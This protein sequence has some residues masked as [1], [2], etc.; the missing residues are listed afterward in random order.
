MRLIIS[1]KERAAETKAEILSH[2]DYEVLTQDDIKYF[3]FGPASFGVETSTFWKGDTIVIPARGHIISSGIRRLRTAKMHE[4]PMFEIMWTIRKANKSRVKV[5]DELLKESSEVIVATDYDREGETIGYN[6]ISHL[7]YKEIPKLKPSAVQRAYYSAL[8]ERDVMSAFENLVPMD[9]ALL[10]QGLARDYS[11]LVIG[12]NL[13]K[14]LT[15]LFKSENPRVTQAFS[16]GRVQSPVLKHLLERTKMTYRKEME[17]FEDK[18]DAY[19]HHI[20]VDGYDYR[21][22]DIWYKEPISE[23]RV[24]D[25]RVE[26]KEEDQAEELFNT[27]DIMTAIEIDPKVL[28]S[29][30]ES[31]YLDGYMT[32]PRTKSRYVDPETLQSL[33]RKIRGY[34]DIPEEFSHEYAPVGTEGK[35]PAIVLT[36]KG[37]EALFQGKVKGHRKLVADVVLNQMVKSFACPLKKTNTIIDIEYDDEERTLTWESKIENMEHAITM[38]DYTEKPEIEEGTYEAVSLRVLSHI[39]SSLFPLFERTV[40]ILTD[41]NIVEW[42]TEENIGTEATRSTF[43]SLLRKRQYTMESNLPTLLGEEVSKIVRDI[44]ITTDLTREMETRIDD[45]RYL[46]DLPEFHEWIK[47]LTGGFIEEI[48]RIEPPKL[49]CP[50]GHPIMLINTPKGLFGRCEICD[51]WVSL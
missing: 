16:L 24:T 32:Y 8:T 22:M 18:T 13:T 4:L 29:S 1:E 15:I 34:M 39:T 27:N 41:T 9:E 47:E 7:R 45:I 25:V 10:T 20:T 21:L 19:R 46:S 36:E 48:S 28:M 38:V 49:L 23:I 12:L 2:G 35:K 3:K 11:D 17:P 42:M 44:G 51:K 50:E 26:E 43:P 37:I 6:I 33:E 30:M 40:S 5:I 14:A 31:L